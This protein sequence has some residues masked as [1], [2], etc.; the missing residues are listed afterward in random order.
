MS[1][2]WNFCSGAWLLLTIIFLVEI[3][4]CFTWR[5]RVCL[6][7]GL[8]QNFVRSTWVNLIGSERHSK[9]IFI[10]RNFDLWR[11]IRVFKI[12]RVIIEFCYLDTIW[13]S[14]NFFLFL[15]LLFYFIL[16]LW[17]CFRFIEL[18][19]EL[20]HSVLFFFF[21]L[22][23]SCEIHKNRNRHRIVLFPLTICSRNWKIPSLCT[24][25]NI[26]SL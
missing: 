9:N 23:D 5:S 2:E 26:Y 14:K 7:S 11:N 13:F 25:K 4:Y 19:P 3:R 20:F 17:F 24:F 21:F 10:D 1:D 12:Y 18:K 8:L 22:V 15:F 16:W 6:L